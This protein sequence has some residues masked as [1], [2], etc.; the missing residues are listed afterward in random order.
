MATHTETVSTLLV[1]AGPIGVEVAVALERAG[2]EYTHI[3]AERLGHT[4][5][6]WSPGTRFFSSPERIA[7]A[8]VPLVTQGQDKATREEYLAYLRQVVAQFGLEIR[9]GERVTDIK[10]LA[11]THGSDR[12]ARFEV[13]VERTSGQNAG[14]IAYRARNIV[15]AIGDM[16]APRKIDVPGEDLPHVSH[17]LGDVHSYFGREVVIVGGRNSAVEAAIRLHRVGARVTMVVRSDWIDRDRI[18]YWLLPE[19]EWL[20]RKDVIRIHTNARVGSITPDELRLETPD[21]PGTLTP[22]DV[23]LLTGYVQDPS[24][25]ERAGVTLGGDQRAPIFDRLTMQTDVPGIYVAGT[26]TAGTQ[27]RFKVFIETSH[28]HAGR[29]AR[30]IA[31]EPPIDEPDPQVEVPAARLES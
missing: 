26:A 3:E 16:H 11:P 21:G 20:I 14:R 23:L 5:S 6:W 1:G 28:V 24:L 27:A 22:D 31:G 7:I 9:T 30:S 25:F 15:L 29:I 17:Y 13:D 4:L 2:L 19:V 10:Q 8:G 12:A 18:K